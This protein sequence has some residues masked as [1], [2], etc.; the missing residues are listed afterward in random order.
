MED[1][2]N[3]YEASQIQVLEGLEAVRKRPGM[4]IGST[5]VRGLHHLVYEIVDNSIDE[6]LAGYCTHIE[7]VINEDNSVTVSDDGRGMPV[8]M[9]PK[10]GKPAVEV[11]MTILHAGGKF[12]GGG[13]KVS[14]GLHGVGASVVN[15]LSEVCEVTVKREGF[16]W[17]QSFGRGLAKSPLEK[18][19]ETEETG[20]MVY[21]KPD[22]LI[23][24][25]ID[26]DF[27]ILSKRL[28]EVAFL[29][30]G[31]KISFED[32]RV[33]KK[34][35][36]QYEGGIKSFV[37]Y[38][39]RNKQALHP[40]PIYVEGVKDDYMVE[41][42]LQYNDGYTENIFSFANNIDTVEGG[43]HL[44]GFKSALTRVFNDYARKFGLLKEADKNL[45]GDDI[46]EGLTAV[47]SVKLTDPQFEGQTKTKLGNS[48]VRGI[49]DNI[50]GEGVSTYLEENPLVGKIVI[51]KG[52]LAARAR[53]AARKARELTRKSVLERTSLP[54]KLADCSSKD[55]LECEI[56]IVEGDS[57]GGSAKQGRNRRFQAILPLRGKILNVE[58]QRLD[59][60][61]NSESIRSMITAF[62]AGIGDEFDLE[63]RRYNRII[64]MTDADVDGAHI[65]TLLLTFFYRYMR[66]LVDEGHV[67]IAQPPLFKVTKQK[68]DYYAYTDKELNDILEELGG[69]DNSIA[70][71]RYKGLGEMNAEQ[72]WDTTMDPE[73]RILLKATVDDAM[74]A[75]EIFTILM[76][77]KVEPRREFIQ[78]NAKKVMNL[79]I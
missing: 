7:I 22:P 38:L 46:R 19:G 29:N 75:D 62:G 37:S 47:V 33:D 36:Y 56:Y 12:G 17:K 8:G 79:D 49:V 31:I 42:A 39:N 57:A 3:I 44:I 73:K 14:G 27:D 10:M 68:K 52:L 61:L 13:Y 26:F 63:K 77:D 6:A 30:K 11:I 34:D 67:Y 66:G 35:Q 5:S 28:R 45:S 51:E 2:N 21:F 18:I 23:F 76:G 64:I 58:K 41:I 65:R 50:M 60:I 71:Q 4:Y 59:K 72:L 74:A 55:P 40:E 25:E 15:A 69:K 20:T 1:N 78:E 53:E 32:K 54:G 16:I 43:T 48:E 9:H 70:I 24:E